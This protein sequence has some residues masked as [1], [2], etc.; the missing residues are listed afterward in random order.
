LVSL[1]EYKI[2]N[3]MFPDVIFLFSSF[4]EDNI[5]MLKLI[6]ETCT[7]DTIIKIC[8]CIL[9]KNVKLI[10]TSLIT[11]IQ[12]SLELS[13][14]SQLLMWKLI[15]SHPI[16]V[17]QTK[18]NLVECLCFLLQNKMTTEEVNASECIENL[19]EFLFNYFDFCKKIVTY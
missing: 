14:Y 7:Y 9:Y 19:F 2:L 4:F 18:E 1:G 8:E 10:K 13:S 3:D 17:I 16:P 12:N 5:G 6:V 11:T 15:H